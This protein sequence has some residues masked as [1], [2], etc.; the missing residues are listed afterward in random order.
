MSSQFCVLQT[1]PQFR[2]IIPRTLSSSLLSDAH[3]QSMF[4]SHPDLSAASLSV[5]QRSPSPIEVFWSRISSTFSYRQKHGRYN[6]PKMPF[7]CYEFIG[8]VFFVETWTLF[9]VWSVIITMSLHLL[10][11]YRSVS[12]VKSM[13]R[14]Y[15]LLF[16]NV[17][18]FRWS[19]MSSMKL[20]TVWICML[21]SNVF[22][23]IFFSWEIT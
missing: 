9:K 10:K 17:G 1:F 11:W 21:L 15:S 22:F 4:S 23:V 5:R 20:K 8:K 2:P 19:S 16:V 6:L 7:L 12:G 13:D 14:Q 18:P 3:K